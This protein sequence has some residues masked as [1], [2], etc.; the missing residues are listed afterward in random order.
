MKLIHSAFALLLAGGSTVGLAETGSS[1][2]IASWI[3]TVEQRIE[4]SLAETAWDA[5][6]SEPRLVVVRFVRG[7]DGRPTD[8]TVRQSS[9]SQ[10]IDRKALATVSNLGALPQLPEGYPAAMPISMRVLFETPQEHLAQAQAQSAESEHAFRKPQ[11]KATTVL[12]SR[13]E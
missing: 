13:Y 4:A 9:G 10:E 12:A 2:A 5:T 7:A 1:T 6:P 8:V 11:R 3:G